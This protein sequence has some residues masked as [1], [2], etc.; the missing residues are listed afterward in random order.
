MNHETWT[1]SQKKVKLLT[2]RLFIPLILVLGMGSCSIPETPIP[3][4]QENQELVVL[5]RNSP[6]TYYEDAHGNYAGLEY[7]LVKLFAKEL[8]VDVRFVVA[9]EFSKI[10]PLLTK[11]QVHL[12]AAGLTITPEREKII[13]FGPAY[14]TVQQQIVYNT[15]ALKPNDIGDLIGKKIEVIAGSSYVERLKQA[16]KKTPKLAWHEITTTEIEELLGKVANGE[17]DYSVADSHFVSMTQNFFPN[18]GIAFNLG[19]PEQLAWAFPKDVDPYLFGK[20]QQF[21]DRIQKDGTLRRLLDRYYGHIDRLNRIDVATFLEKMNSTLPSYRK[22]FQEAQDITDIDWR[23]IAA[24]GYQESH[25]D[26]LATSPTGVRGLMMLTS[27][28]ADYLGVND[29]LN[30]K[31]NVP[32]GA[33]YLL[34]LKEALPERIPEPDKTWIALAAYNTGMGHLEDAR[35]LAQRLKLNPDSWTDMKKALPL[36]SKTAYHT[37]LKHGYARGGEAVILVEN[38]RNY[39]N[40]L[41]KYEP[42]Y[43]SP[44]PALAST[45][46]GLSL[47]DSPVHP[48]KKVT[49]KAQ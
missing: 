23:L 20:A 47:A 39:H 12:V 19:E 29:R 41:M 26:P 18:L 14:Q 35:I 42:A 27:D 15:F 10:I 45:K 21:F 6:T 30:P 9:T 34:A 24:L 37:T 36:L 22:L 2:M 38:I 1:K 28:T 25:W 43:S 44:Y 5:T 7:D 46:R 33:R 3:P 48:D 4:V 13:R 49:L 17:V 8:G 16:K 32:A 11:K 31:E 40:I